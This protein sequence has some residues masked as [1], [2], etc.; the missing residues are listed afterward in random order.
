M[1]IDSLTVEPFGFNFTSSSIFCLS[2]MTFSG[3]FECLF[4]PEDSSSDFPKKI[5]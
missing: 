5:K 1:L 3:V 2:K 4:L